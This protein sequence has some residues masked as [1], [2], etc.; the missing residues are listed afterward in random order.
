MAWHF[1]EALNGNKRLNF[2]LAA[3]DMEWKI[4]LSLWQLQEKP[5]YFG[6]D[7]QKRAS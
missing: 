4:H 2:H 6:E 5:D 7:L 1:W 3:N